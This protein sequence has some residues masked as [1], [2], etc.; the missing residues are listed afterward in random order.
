[1]LEIRPGARVRCSSSSRELISALLT[2]LERLDSNARA[3]GARRAAEFRPLLAARASRRDW[4]ESD[5]AEGLIE[6]LLCAL[7]DCAADRSLYFGR[8]S[9]DSDEFGFWRSED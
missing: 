5:E 1:M 4:F 6:D 2:E 9:P 7:T 3:V 8:R